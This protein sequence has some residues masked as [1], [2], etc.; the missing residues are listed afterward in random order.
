M[1]VI[2]IGSGMSGL[3]AAAYLGQAGHDVTVYE[4]YSRIGGVTATIEEEGYRWDLGPLLLEKFSPGQIGHTI[5][6]ELGIADEVSI[7]RDDRDIVFPDF[8]LIRPDEYRG[9]YW[10]QKRLK[11]L[12]PAEAEGIDAYYAFY[13]TMLDLV[14]LSERAKDKKGPAAWL[15]KLG[16]LRLF[17]R[18]KPMSALSAKEVMTS[19][20]SDPRLIAVFTG[21]LADFCVLPSEF[22]G[23]GIPLCNVETA[24]DKRMPLSL[25]KAGSRPGY[26]YIR[27]GVGRLVEAMAAHIRENGGTILTESPVETILIEEGRAAGV[28][29]ANGEKVN[30][31]V[32][33]ASGGTRELFYKMVGIEYLQKELIQQIEGL[34]PM[35]SVLMVH[36]GID[37]DPA[38]YQRNALRYYYGT[39]GIEEAVLKC[40][41]GEYTEG[42]DGF[43]IYIP[44]VHSPDMAPEGKHAV[45]I[46]TIA[47]NKLDEGTWQERREELADKL[48]EKAERYMPGLK[49]HT[50]HR[51]VMTPEDFKEITHLGHHAFGGIAPVMGKPNPSHKTSVEGLYFIGA[52]S[53]SGGGVTG[54]M[55]GARDVA[56]AIL[57]RPIQK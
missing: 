21:I 17:K 24:F 44:S 36:L 8:A 11:E 13:D 56:N 5:L 30:A 16:M 54:V 9:P 57:R 38:V 32:I 20:F 37:M 29:L 41:R 43:L 2:I 3:T 50:L 47:S 19:F 51:I 26:Y 53:E 7:M 27:D 40:R 1:K 28:R 10:R 25:T 23:L 6:T 15:T 49:A 34:Q 46:Y 55:A 31:D 45:T 39:Y 22:Q 48:V 4:Q 35:E 52:Q 33:L 42:E 18:L 12:F 14:A